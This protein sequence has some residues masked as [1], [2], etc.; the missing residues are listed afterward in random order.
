M[1]TKMRFSIFWLLVSVLT[2]GI[3]VF[4][5]YGNRVLTAPLAQQ[6]GTSAESAARQ[7]L[8][9]Q[10]A[11]PSSEYGPIDCW[12]WEAARVSRDKL[13]WQL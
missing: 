13:T 9:G 6:R 4:F 11:D 7:S 8:L 3:S 5:L 12:W 1:T 10:F 2:V